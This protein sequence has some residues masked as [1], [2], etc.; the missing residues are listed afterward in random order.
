MPL[1]ITILGDFV[2]STQPGIEAAESKVKFWSVMENLL[3]RKGEIIVRSSLSISRMGFWL[4]AQKDLDDQDE[5]RTLIHAQTLARRLRSEIDW[6]GWNDFYVVLL[7]HY[8]ESI[9][10]VSSE[11]IY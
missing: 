10:V 8:R 11:N 6:H 7:D 5:S 1:I 3:F 2:K 9:K 4:I